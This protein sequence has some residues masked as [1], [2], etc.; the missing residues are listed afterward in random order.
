MMLVFPVVLDP[1]I[2]I[3]RLVGR[4]DEKCSRISLNSHFLPTKHFGKATG[5]LGTSKNNG[6]KISVKFAGNIASTEL[7]KKYETLLI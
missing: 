1:W 5:E 2:T 7:P 6:L 3:P 4:S